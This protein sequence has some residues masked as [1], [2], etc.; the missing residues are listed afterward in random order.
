MQANLSESSEVI[1]KDSFEELEEYQPSLKE[2]IA[3]LR[4]RLIWCLVSVSVSFFV[5]ITFFIN[6][7][8]QLLSQPIKERG[9][10]FIYL[11]LAEAMTAQIKVAFVAALVVSAPIIFWQI[12]DFIRPALYANEK[13]AVLLFSLSSVVLFVAG[14]AFGY[15]VVFLSAITFFVYMGE[16]LATPMLSISLYV[17]FMFGFVLSFGVVFELPVA[18]YVL[19]K[20]G[21]VTV[22]QLTSARKYVVL[23]I[24]VVAAFL[25]PPDVLSQCLMAVPM[26]VLYEIGILVAKL[27]CK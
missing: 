16:N 24:F 3:E 8:M 25:T 20:L 14:V 23:A 18:I 7:L 22:K 5:I 1:A 10:E 27:G 12:W 19:C 6:D 17:G 9:I 15:V 21:L 2:H 26:L 4:K 13:K 11:G